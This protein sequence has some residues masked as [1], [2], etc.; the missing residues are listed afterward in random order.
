MNKVHESIWIFVS[1]SQLLY[2]YS[3]T[4]SF[5]RRCYYYLFDV[6]TFPELVG[7]TPLTVDSASPAP[8]GFV[9]LFLSYRDTR[10]TRSCVCLSC[11]S[12]QKLNLHRVPYRYRSTIITMQP[13]STHTIQHTTSSPTGL[14]HPTTTSSFTTATTSKTKWNPE[15]LHTPWLT[16]ISIFTVLMASVTIIILFVSHRLERTIQRRQFDEFGDIELGSIEPS[17][18]ETINPFDFDSDSDTSDT[19]VCS[20]ASD[21]ASSCSTGHQV[22][23]RVR[24]DDQGDDGENV[25][26]S[27]TLHGK[28]WSYVKVQWSNMQERMSGGLDQLTDS[29]VQGV[30]RL[31]G[32]DAMRKE[33]ETV[34]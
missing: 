19:D 8:G 29:M 22:R 5:S 33:F 20:S 3:T 10:G 28:V 6:W 13:Y 31:I 7:D 27:T 21:D 18:F 14:K 9:F 16:Y 26:M 2:P 24:R 11:R 25:M 4:A 12:H 30:V 23:R 34:A 15:H 32:E 17:S 1:G